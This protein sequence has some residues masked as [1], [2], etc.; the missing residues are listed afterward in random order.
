MKVKNL[1]DRIQSLWIKNPREGG[2]SLSVEVRPHDTRD[3]SDY[4]PDKSMMPDFDK[5][6]EI[7][8]STKN[9]PSIKVE[10][11]ITEIQEDTTGD[12]QIPDEEKFSNPTVLE[13]KFICEICGAEFASARGLSSHKNRTHPEDN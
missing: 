9:I 2:R 12:T 11:T 7:V 10:E 13:D 1:T 6:F 4:Y 5:N 8:G 3:I